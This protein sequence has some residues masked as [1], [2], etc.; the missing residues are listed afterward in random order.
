[1]GIRLMT[2]MADEVHY[3]SSLNLNNLTLVFDGEGSRGPART[4]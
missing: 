2:A 4:E 3:T 1:M